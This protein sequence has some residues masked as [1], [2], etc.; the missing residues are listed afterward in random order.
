MLLVSAL[1]VAST[2]NGDGPRVPRRRHLPRS[3][4]T[5]RAPA[6]ASRRYHCAVGSRRSEAQAALRL[7]AAAAAGDEAADSLLVDAFA[8]AE[9]AALK[10]AYL[11][12]FLLALLA[13]A[14]D[15]PRHE[16][17]ERVA[18]LIAGPRERRAWPEGLE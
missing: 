17:V 6:S 11:S 9:E 4:R 7:V 5:A 13:D 12:G 2:E 15:V 3:A 10:H 16:A 1:T 8:S 14:W 18:E